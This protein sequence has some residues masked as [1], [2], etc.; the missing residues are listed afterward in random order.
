MSV[1][2]FERL[3]AVQERAVASSAASMQMEGMTVTD[4]ERVAAGELAA[5]QIDF[6][7]Y[8]RRVDAQ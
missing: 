2:Q 7:E 4:V 8:A 5:G 6:A 3:T 1:E